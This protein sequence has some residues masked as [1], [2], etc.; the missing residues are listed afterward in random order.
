MNIDWPTA[1]GRSYIAQGEHAVSDDPNAVISTIL[2]SCIAVCLW[3]PVRR[4]GGMNHILLPE[5]AEVGSGTY[6]FG[7]VSMELL[8]NDLRKSGADGA[9]LRAKLFGGAAMMRGLSDIG[10]RNV[11]FA[12][13]WLSREAIP[14]DVASTGGTSARQ[15]RFW[16][17]SG[18]VRQR[19]VTSATLPEPRIGSTPE[20]NGVEL[21]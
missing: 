6:R 3:D 4:I 2:G 5:G 19:V 11:E 13:G 21:F 9:R 16:P 18:L 8:V 12:I 1:Q 14:C 10:A 17:Y 15:V 7:A 20:G